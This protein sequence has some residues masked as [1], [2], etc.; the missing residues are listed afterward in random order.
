MS[1]VKA[2]IYLNRVKGPRKQ[3]R[4]SQCRHLSADDHLLLPNLFTPDTIKNNPYIFH[5][6]FMNGPLFWSLQNQFT[7]AFAEGNL[8]HK[9]VGIKFV[10]NKKCFCKSDLEVRF[11][12]RAIRATDKRLFLVQQQRMC[13]VFR[14]FK[15]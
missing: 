7:F 5:I 2:F 11:R 15:Y 12:N 4:A 14:C 8:N 13:E 1:R 9:T 6:K 10:L 3:E